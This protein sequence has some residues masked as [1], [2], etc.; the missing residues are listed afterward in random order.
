[1]VAAAP[2]A[3]RGAGPSAG[4][5]GRAAQRWRGERATADRCPPGGDVAGLLASLSIFASLIGIAYR[6]ARLIPAALLLALIA[7]AI[8][9]RH[10]R[11]AGFA[12]AVGARLLR[13]RHGARRRDRPPALLSPSPGGIP[14]GTTKT[15]S[16]HDVDGLNAGYAS[17]LL[18]QYLENPEAVPR[19]VAG[20]VRER[21]E[22]ARRDPSRSRAAGRAAAG[23][24]QRPRRARRGAAA[25]AASAASPSP[26]PRRPR[27]RRRRRTRQLLRGRRGRDGARQG[28]PHARAPGRA[29]RP[30]R[31]RAGR[32]PGARAGAPRAEADAGAAA[33]DPGRHP[34]RPRPGRDARRR[35]AAAARDL[36]RDDRLR[37]RAHLR[38]RAARLAPQGDRVGP[39]PP[40][41]STRTTSAACSSA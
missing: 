5:S 18:E 36:L 24:R 3:G 31:L 6:P 12:I 1:M 40:R 25:S 14:V 28:P 17:A 30:A 2:Q 26:R 20:A 39:L 38:P 35:P 23:G 16:M 21:G 11:L 10:H 8:G 41:R 7:A 29:A 27:P 13:R 32:R 15:M 19:G 9:G 4:R 33:T 37:D 34:A 22:R